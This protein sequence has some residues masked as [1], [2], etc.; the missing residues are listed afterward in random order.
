MF[1]YTL[2]VPKMCLLISKIC[3]NIGEWAQFSKFRTT[4][5]SLQPLRIVIEFYM[6]INFL[7]IMLWRFCLERRQNNPAWWETCNGDPPRSRHAWCCPEEAKKMSHCTACL[8]LWRLSVF[9]LLSVPGVLSVKIFIIRHGDKLSDCSYSNG[10]S[11]A[12]AFGD[13]PPLTQTGWVQ[14][15]IF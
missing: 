8:M 10:T 11:Y 15:S 6:L 4:P 5:K 3:R 7:I 14:V 9:A 1:W 2:I 12:A 13:N